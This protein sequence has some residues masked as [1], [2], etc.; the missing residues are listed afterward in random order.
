MG[1]LY[2]LKL[3]IGKRV[4]TEAFIQPSISLSTEQT[5]HST[6]SVLFFLLAEELGHIPDT[7]LNR[8][9]IE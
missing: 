3:M 5:H 4:V 6:C 1:G 9:V 2:A 7:R 8:C